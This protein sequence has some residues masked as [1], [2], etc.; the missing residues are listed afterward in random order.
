M[1]Y[2]FVSYGLTP[3]PSRWIEAN[4]AEAEF[5]WISRQCYRFEMISELGASFT[6]LCI[7]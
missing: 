3:R 4:M 6:E 1:L 7:Q 2:E 5:G